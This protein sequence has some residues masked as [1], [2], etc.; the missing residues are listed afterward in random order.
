MSSL[1]STR[2]TFAALTVAAGMHATIPAFAQD[3]NDLLTIFGGDGQRAAR[4]AQTEW[5]RLPPA[6]MAC[7]DQRLRRKGS[8]VEAL[9]RRG[10]KPS[11]ARLIELRSSCRQSVEAV[12]TDTAPA[13]SRDATGSSTPTVPASNPTEPKDVGVTLPSS[14]ESVGPVVQQGNV[15]LKDRLPKRGMMPWSSAAFLV[16]VV[17]IAMLLGIVIYLFIRWR[18][19]GQRTVAV[20]AATDHVPEKNSERGVGKALTETIIGKTKEVVMPINLALADKMIPVPDEN[21]QNATIS[22]SE[23]S[24]C[25]SKIE[26]TN[27]EILPDT[28]LSERSPDSSVVENVAQLAKLYAIG[29]PSEKEFQ[30]IKGLIPQS[31][32]DSQEPK[33]T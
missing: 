31:L 1:C 9:I 6:E 23:N 14:A 5:R 29:T 30:R 25:S 11:A 33:L 10:V 3:I 18:K 19:T 17:A 13:L 7:I 22:M 15:E 24:A 28:I 20:S 12:Q 21:G 26:S 16:A 32:G 4:H 8:S 27:E 2:F